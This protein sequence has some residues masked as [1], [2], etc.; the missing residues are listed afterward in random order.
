MRWLSSALLL[1]L[2]AALV[3]LILRVDAGNV[4]FF[5]HPYR[6]DLS[7]NLFVVALLL[8][9]AVVYWTA[10][11]VQKMVDFPQQVRLYR[12]RREEIGS[13]LTAR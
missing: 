1:A 6:V 8:I 9:L 2:A 12:A 4:A 7:L 11:A 10:R 3:A 5:V 13:Q